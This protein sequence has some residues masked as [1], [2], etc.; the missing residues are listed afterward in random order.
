MMTQVSFPPAARVGFRS[1]GP[2]ITPAWHDE[3]RQLAAHIQT[4]LGATFPSLDRVSRWRTAT[5]HVLMRNSYADAGVSLGFGEAAIWM[6]IRDDREFRL[7]SIW[8]DLKPAAER[9]LNDV[10]RRA[11]GAPLAG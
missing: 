5:H 6:A 2:W 10:D 4:E 11:K 1:F 7:R 3:Y 8:R 9:W